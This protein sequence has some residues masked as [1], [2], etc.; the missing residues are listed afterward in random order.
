MPTKKL[1][2]VISEIR[3]KKII[4][5]DCRYFNGRPPNGDQRICLFYRFERFTVLK[6]TGF[7]GGYLLTLVNFVPSLL[8]A[9][10]EK[11]KNNP[12]PLMVLM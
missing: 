2:G 1:S 3:R 7:A 8:Q 9:D 4:G 10:G 11:G 12:R 6:A 5:S